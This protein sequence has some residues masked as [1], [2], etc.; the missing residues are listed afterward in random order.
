M[1]IPSSSSREFIW[2]PLWPARRLGADSVR[3]LRLNNLNFDV[4]TASQKMRI[5][6]SCPRFLSRLKQGKDESSIKTFFS[7]NRSIFNAVSVRLQ[8]TV[9]EESIE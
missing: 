7:E 9:F 8:F 1:N 5:F 3:I 2:R 6:K 4:E